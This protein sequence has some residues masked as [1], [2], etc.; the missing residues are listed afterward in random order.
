M[1]NYVFITGPLQKLK[2]KLK[3]IWEQG[4]PLMRIG[5][6]LGWYR[7]TS[8][9]RQFRNI[10][11]WLE[12]LNYCPDGGHGNSL[13]CLFL[14]SHSL[15]CEAQFS[16]AAHQK[17]IL[18]IFSFFSLGWMIKGICQERWG[19]GLKCRGNQLF[20]NNKTKQRTKTTPK[21]KTSRQPED[22]STVNVKHSHDIRQRISTGLQTQ[23]PI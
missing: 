5:S 14:K 6:E 7:H 20:F 21:G 13:L 12:I 10:L 1:I 2:L 8:S 17:Y 9:S 16:F 15:I 11:C 22:W 19:R 4:G 23:G 3:H 18:Y